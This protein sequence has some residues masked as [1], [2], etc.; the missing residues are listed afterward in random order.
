M[1][2]TKITK[3]ARKVL[4]VKLK[5]CGAVIVAAG[6]ASR[7]G[8]IDKILAPLGG[9]AV[10]VR[11]VRNFQECDAIREIVIVTRPDL[12]VPISDLCHGFSKVKAVVVGGDSRDASVHLGLNALS[13]KCKLVAVQD[14]A[15]PFS[16]WQLIDR[17]VRAAAAYG[18]AAPAI[19]VKDTI[20]VVRGGLVA[21]TPDR[22]T[23]KAVQTPQVFDFDLLR[24]ALKKAKMDGISITDDCSAVEHMGMSVKIVDGDE[25]N[26]KI[27]TPM[28]LKIAEMVLEEAK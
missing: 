1:D 19:P 8:G 20:K 9:E 4:N 26:I 18:A 7:M 28:D 2:A 10:I 13:E 25:R 6:S 22:S 24:G 3:P 15:R 12:I 5:Y 23:L 11:T 17:V 14:G 21:E 16:G 27:T